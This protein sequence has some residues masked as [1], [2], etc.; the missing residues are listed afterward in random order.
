MTFQVLHSQAEHGKR[1][2]GGQ[3]T[4]YQSAVKDDMDM[5][6]I[7]SKTWQLNAENR[8]EWRRMVKEGAE[9]PTNKW[10]AAEH[11]KCETRKA[12]ELL[13]CYDDSKNV[14][15]LVNR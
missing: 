3:P 1:K 9:I 4:T 6:G 5:F 7:D 8:P 2:I 10:S 11:A 14:K 12:S 15:Q 13:I